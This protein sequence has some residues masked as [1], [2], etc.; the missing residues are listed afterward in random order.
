[1]AK[2]TRK[3][4]DRSMVDPLDVRTQ[5]RD[6]AYNVDVEVNSTNGFEGTEDSDWV[7]IEEHKVT[8]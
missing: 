5:V 1:M 3:F 6:G 8:P 4:K 2:N 7:N